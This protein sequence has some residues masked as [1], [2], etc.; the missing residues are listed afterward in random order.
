VLP[1]LI[2]VLA[3]ALV[4]GCGSATQAEHERATTA[5][6]ASLAD[7]RTKP[8]ELPDS[9]VAAMGLDRGKARRVGLFRGRSLWV[10]PTQKGETCLVDAGDAAVGAACGPTLFGPHKLAYTQATDGGP[11]PRPF[12]LLR[13]SGVAAPGVGSVVLELSDGS[14]V[15]LVPNDAGAFVYDESSAA[16]ASGITPVAL[17]A[18]DESA[19]QVDRIELPRAPL[20]P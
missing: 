6:P 4:T 2:L 15:V 11:P 16:L 1:L 7:A 17:V 5:R 10:A 18:R 3:A 8:G 13:L 12:T 9:A 14:N 20:V 19:R